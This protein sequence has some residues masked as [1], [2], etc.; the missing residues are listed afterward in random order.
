MCVVVR[1]PNGLEC[2]TVAELMKMI[3]ESCLVRSVHYREIDKSSCL[4]QLDIEE[5][6]KK[7][8]YKYTQNFMDYAAELI[9]VKDIVDEYLTKYGFNGLFNALGGCS[10][11]IGDLMPCDSDGKDC[12]PGVVV[13][14]DHHCGSVEPCLG[15]R[16][17]GCPEKEEEI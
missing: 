15:Y 13:G 6:L 4:C 3:D 9:T 16:G 8:G 2:E 11:G 14:C 7:A 12:Y 5:T 1:F 17:A 10:C